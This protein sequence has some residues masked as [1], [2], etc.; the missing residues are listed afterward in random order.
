M[1]AEVKF[2]GLTR[3]A[4]AVAASRSGAGYLG[5]IFAES[6]R[7]LGAEAARVVLDAGTSAFSGSRARRVGVFGRAAAEEVGH[8]AREAELDIVQLHGDPDPHEIDAVRAHFAG[9]VWAVLRLEGAV[10][11][12]EAEAVAAAADALVIDA[13]APGALGGTGRSLDWRGLSASLAGLRSHAPLVL[14]GGLTPDNV[15]VAI[16]ILRPDVV[17]VSSGVE[18]SP[19]VKDHERM[20]AFAEAAGVFPLGVTR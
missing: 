7:R 5:V 3:A 20:R 2:C 10:L 8:I 11:P 15:A 13:K 9:D 1:P 19:G 12:D 17:D 4:D 18:A 6:R 14:A 16:A